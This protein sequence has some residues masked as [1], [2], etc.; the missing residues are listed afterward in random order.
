MPQTLTSLLV[1]LVFS[2]KE[3]IPIIT[4]EVEPDQ[5]AYIGGILKNHGSRLLDA[6]GTRDHIHL[7]G[8]QS[9]NIAVAALLKDVKKDSSSWI[10]NAWTRIQKL[11]LAGWLWSIFIWCPGFA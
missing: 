8:S 10:K 9:K 5:F 4:P 1:H 3:R 2:T 6:G 7:L 11:S